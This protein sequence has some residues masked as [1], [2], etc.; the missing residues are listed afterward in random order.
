MASSAR[1]T[2]V[3]VVSISSATDTTLVAAQ[4]GFKVRVWQFVLQNTHATTDV[5]VTFKSNAGGTAISGAH[6]LKAAGGS[7]ALP[8]SE[9]AYYTS[10]SG[11]AL[12]ITTSAAGVVAGTVNYSVEQV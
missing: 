8:Y 10:A 6:L 11:E 3:S 1:V 7:F 12:T 5:T 4:P 2:P 9:M